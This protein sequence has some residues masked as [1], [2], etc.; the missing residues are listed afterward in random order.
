[1][2]RKKRVLT[3]YEERFSTMQES[4][5]S[6]VTETVTLLIRPPNIGTSEKRKKAQKCPAR[7]VEAKF[8]RIRQRQGGFGKRTT[9]R[10]EK[11]EKMGE[12]RFQGGLTDDK[13]R[14]PADHPETQPQ[15][16]D[17]SVNDRCLPH[18]TFVHLTKLSSSSRLST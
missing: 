7:K 10:A 17:H 1:M 6:L 15:S 18:L 13:I 3:L 5:A 2:K 16:T 12:M 14:G 11:D 4:V 9:G 8:I